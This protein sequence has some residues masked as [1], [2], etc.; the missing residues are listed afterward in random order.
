MSDDRRSTP[1]PE[2]QPQLARDAI[3]GLDRLLSLS[4][5]QERLLA[6]HLGALVRLIR[7][8]GEAGEGT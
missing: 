5:P 6:R 7:Q 3:A 4:P 1:D 2:L 8:A